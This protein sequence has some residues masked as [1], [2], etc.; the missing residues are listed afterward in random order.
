MGLDLG[1]RFGVG[2][3][4]VSLRSLGL[5]ASRLGLDSGP[6]GVRSIY[7]P[8]LVAFVGGGGWS[9]GIGGLVGWF[10]LGPGEIYN[11]W[12]RCGRN[13]YTNVNYNNLRGCA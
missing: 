11:P 5:Y 6:R 2:L 4:T 1:G 3:R 13:C 10:P 9:V 7:A 12:Y 8:A